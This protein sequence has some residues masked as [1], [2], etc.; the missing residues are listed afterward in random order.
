MIYHFNTAGVGRSSISSLSL[1]GMKHEF[2]PIQ[3]RP[4]DPDMSA[5]RHCCPFCPRSFIDDFSLKSG[6]KA[7]QTII[8]PTCDHQRSKAFKI[9]AFVLITVCAALRLEHHIAKTEMA[10][11]DLMIKMHD[12]LV[13]SGSRL[14]RMV[15]TSA[16]SST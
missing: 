9:A 5:V 6:M 7:R 8:W 12:H 15:G 10:T 1:N 3:F 16:L 11:V 2:M 4:C 13:L 14:L